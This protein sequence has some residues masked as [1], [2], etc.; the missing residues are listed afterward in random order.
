MG[1][2]VVMGGAVDD[3][4]CVVVASRP[5]TNDY[6]NIVYKRVEH[7][8][9]IAVAVDLLSTSQVGIQ[10]ALDKIRRDKRSL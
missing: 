7:V 6:V 1:M 9:R 10:K 3:S 5:L 2:A 8:Q 4:V